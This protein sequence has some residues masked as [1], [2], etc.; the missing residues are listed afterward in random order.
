MAEIVPLIFKHLGFHAGFQQESSDVAALPTQWAKSE[1][2]PG[3]VE[4]S[5][6]RLSA[7]YATWAC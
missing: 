4:S 5:D 1:I 6:S 2:V 7:R 3:L